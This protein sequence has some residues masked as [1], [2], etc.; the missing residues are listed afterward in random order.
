MGES[1]TACSREMGRKGVRAGAG[2]GDDRA[3]VAGV[4]ARG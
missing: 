4:N 2:Y 3:D 1:R